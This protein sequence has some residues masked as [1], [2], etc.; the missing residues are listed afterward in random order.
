MRAKVILNPKGFKQ[1]EENARKA[2]EQ[3]A[4][5]TKTDIVT[6]RVIPYDTGEMQN[7]QTFTDLKDTD[8]GIARIVTDAPQARRLYFHPEY[9]FQ[10]VNNPNAGGEWF[11]PWING[12]KKD[13]F[14]K[15]YAERL[16]RLNAKGGG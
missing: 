3:A 1:I 6:A 13:F 7:N 16:R 14:R 8:K 4:A 10:K 12:K 2:L 9:N 11:E 15:A 5:A